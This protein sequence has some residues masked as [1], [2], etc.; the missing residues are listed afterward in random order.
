[1]RRSQRGKRKMIK[2]KRERIMERSIKA[3]QENEKNIRRKKNYILMKR[4]K[5]RRKEEKRER[6]E[7]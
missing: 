1:M 3:E 4:R 2:R 7:V 6:G 5:R